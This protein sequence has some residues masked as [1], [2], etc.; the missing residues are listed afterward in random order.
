MVIFTL[1]RAA[2]WKLD[3]PDW[4]GRLR[5]VSKEKEAI[6][7]LEDKDSGEKTRYTGIAA[8]WLI[9]SKN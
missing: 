6:I 1:F 2:D 5:V 9:L 8:T 7:K 4:V 3:E